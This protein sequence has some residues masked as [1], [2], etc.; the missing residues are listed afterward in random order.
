M[1]NVKDSFALIL[2]F[3]IASVLWSVPEN[4]DEVFDF[5]NTTGE[6]DFVICQLPNSV[7]FIG[8]T[9]QYTNAPNL[10]HSA[11]KALVLIPGNEDIIKCER[12]VTAPVLCS[13]NDTRG[14]HAAVE[15]LT[16]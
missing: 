10:S 11:S 2:S 15:E 5:K 13:R 4:L 7:R 8:F 3:K 16:D 12:G 1:L 6:G 9:L 14:G